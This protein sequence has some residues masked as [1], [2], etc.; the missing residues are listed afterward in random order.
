M[1]L[2]NHRWQ[3]SLHGGLTYC[4][5]SHSGNNLLRVRLFARG[6]PYIEIVPTAS[7]FIGRLA[8]RVSMR[9]V[10]IRERFTDA[11]AVLQTRRVLRG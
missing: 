6:V 9:P 7:L 3:E 10:F 2:V 4:E 11:D 5:T 8:E 1:K